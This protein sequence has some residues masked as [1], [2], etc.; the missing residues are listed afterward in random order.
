MAK[1]PS[2]GG[3]QPKDREERDPISELPAKY[4][5]LKKL[6]DCTSTEQFIRKLEEAL[7][8]FKGRLRTS[9]LNRMTS[10]QGGKDS[11]KMSGTY[12]EAIG[13]FCK[14]GWD[15]YL[16]G[17]GAKLWRDGS[18]DDFLRPLFN[19]S[20]RNDAPKVVLKRVPGDE[21]IPDKNGL[22]SIEF[23][24][25]NTGHGQVDLGF[26]VS[27]AQNLP[28]FGSRATLTHGVLTVD[29]GPAMIDRATR[30]GFGGPAT[31]TNGQKAAISI[32]WS[33]GTSNKP[34]WALEA[35][36]SPLGNIV[37]EPDFMRVIGMA[38]GDTLT[39]TFGV[40]RPDIGDADAPNGKAASPSMTDESIALA[41]QTGVEL[42]A[43]QVSLIKRRYLQRIAADAYANDGRFLTLASHTTKFKSQDDKS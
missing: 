2:S 24:I 28:L 43:D 19:P 14:F 40:W 11:G 36:G 13:T 31:I 10:A 39:V 34:R 5:G 22:A 16:H 30:K 3:G 6:K 1:R 33:S 23:M 8:Q 38:P 37:V 17:E 9:D 21:P 15:P 7:P 4:T 18:A 41:L 12:Q 20:D 25:G 35:G 26:E 32:T 29:C 27:C 42:S